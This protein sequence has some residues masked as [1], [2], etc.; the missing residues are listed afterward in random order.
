MSDSKPVLPALD[1]STVAAKSGSGYP[2][3]FDAPVKA[4]EVRRLGDLLGLTNFGVNLVRLPPGVTSSQRHWH[5]HEDEFLY[6]LE[7]EPDLITNQG[8]QRLRPGMCAGFPAGKA[9]GH[10]LINRTERDVLLLAVGDCR[11]GL[12]ACDY[13]DLD[14]RGQFVDGQWRYLHRDGT[15]Y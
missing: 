5:T 4:R 1:P 9:D 7:G 15:P 8:T 3:P 12:D 2:P 13:P 11:D 14:L 10:H 6:V